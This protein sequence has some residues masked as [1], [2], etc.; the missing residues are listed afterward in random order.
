MS[1]VW[2]AIAFILGAIASF[3]ATNA[4]FNSKKSKDEPARP[5]PTVSFQSAQAETPKK[6]TLIEIYKNALPDLSVVTDSAKSKMA[7]ESFRQLASEEEFSLKELARLRY[8]ISCTNSNPEIKVPE[9]QN[10]SEPFLLPLLKKAEMHRAEFSGSALAYTK[11]V[12]EF[13][14]QMKSSSDRVRVLLQAKGHLESE[15]KRVDKKFGN[16]VDQN[17]EQTQDSLADQKNPP[18]DNQSTE[19][20]EAQ[21]IL[22]PEL[23]AW[24]PRF[25]VQPSPDK[26]LD[27][28]QDLIQARDFKKGREF[29]KKI[30]VGAQFSKEQK[31]RARQLIRNSYK[32]EQNLKVHVKEAQLYYDW[33][34]KNK[35]SKNAPEAGVYLARAYWTQ[36]AQTK[37]ET[38]LRDVEKKFPGK[39]IGEVHFILGRMKEEDGHFEQA[40]EIYDKAVEAAGRKSSLGI[41]ASFAKAWCLYKIKK[42][43]QAALEFGQNAE[44]AEEVPDQVK[45][46]FWQARSLIKDGQKEP[47]EAGLRQVIEEDPLGFYG[48]LSHRELGIDIPSIESLQK[49]ILKDQGSISKTIAGLLKPEDRKLIQD[50]AFVEEKEILESFLNQISSVPDWNWETQEGMDVLRAYGQAGMYMPLFVVLNKIPKEEREHLLLLHPELLFPMDFQTLIRS[51]AQKENLPSELIFS[52]IRQESAFNPQARSVADAL[53][54]MQVLPSAA[55][56]ISSKLQLKFDHHEDLFLPEL[57]VPIGTHLLKQNFNRYENNFILSVAAYNANDRAIKNWLKSR[58]RDDPVEFIEEIPYEETRAYVKLVMRN[59]IFYRRLG[60]PGQ[61]LAFP[62]E[63]LPSLQAFRIST[64]EPSVSR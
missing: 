21:R 18:T 40:V 4:Y 49:K 36:G 50:L 43:N 29:L 27:V 12:I 35:D 39:K 62:N 56:K 20:Q 5:V 30:T 16:R 19:L 11:A 26:F 13:S 1:K 34:V 25:I 58:F 63:C 24:A 53:G 60:Q 17:Q 64:D 44:T 46:R 28:A 48:L 59:F 41:K 31:R 52:I 42:F 57:N 10:I 22:E 47:G 14:K 55:E 45:A 7:C 32:T 33:L 15:A 23:H 6:P 38:I 9:F 37:G 2:I 8:V 61:N 51:A 54:L 3:F